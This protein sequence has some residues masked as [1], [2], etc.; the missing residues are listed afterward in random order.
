MIHWPRR[1]A[2]E[3]AVYYQI[4]DENFEILCSPPLFPWCLH[5]VTY[6]CPTS[7]SPPYT[8]D[9]Y[10]SLCTCNCA[11]LHPSNPL[12]FFPFFSLLTWSH[13]SNIHSYHLS[14]LLPLTLP[15]A[16]PSLLS[17]FHRT[18]R[19]R[20]RFTVQPSTDTLRWSRCCC[21]SWLTPPWETANRRPLW[22]WQ[23]C[24]DGCRSVR[25]TCISLLKTITM[26][27]G[28]TD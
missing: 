15:A 22:T 27:W 13:M 20:R 8:A 23:H 1:A 2:Q 6:I 5:L 7:N 11:S 21:R 26:N 24:M 19:R 25:V 3:S 18:M 16:C 12:L 17:F 4:S 10:F 14:N 9:S 28:C